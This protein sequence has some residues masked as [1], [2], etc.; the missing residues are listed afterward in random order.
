[1]I[2]EVDAEQISRLDGVAL[3]QLMKR[4]LLAECQLVHIPLRAAAVQ[5]QITVPDGG[6]DGRVEWIGGINSTNYLPSRFNILQSKAQNLTESSIK[7]EVFTSSDKGKDKSDKV[8]PKLNDAVSESLSQGGSYVIFCSYP[9]T[10]Q[11]INKLRKAIEDAIAQTGAA[12]SQLA[13]I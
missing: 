12:P 9:L 7:A 11:K 1:M 5:L 3:V 8:K 6:E 13:K 4:L 10:G 2:F